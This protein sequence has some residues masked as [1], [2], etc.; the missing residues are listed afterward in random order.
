MWLPF[1]CSAQGSKL[2]IM[3]LGNVRRVALFVPWILSACAGAA[4]DRG[5]CMDVPV[6]ENGKFVR[7]QTRCCRDGQYACEW[8]GWRVCADK[9]CVVTGQQCSEEA[10]KSP[11]NAACEEDAGECPTATSAGR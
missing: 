4:S 3:T 8:D 11:S 5:T 7:S 1:A 6:C 10:L 9:S 2:K